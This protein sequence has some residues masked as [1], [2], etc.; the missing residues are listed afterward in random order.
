MA[1]GQPNWPNP[2][3]RSLARG[4]SENWW[5]EKFVTQSFRMK[6]VPL[7]VDLE[8]GVLPAVG[9]EVLTHPPPCSGQIQRLPAARKTMIHSAIAAARPAPDPS[10]A[11]GAPERRQMPPAFANQLENHR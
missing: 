3:A 9:S 7:S 2:V 5:P 6:P 10:R 8:N 4:N 1:G 11:T